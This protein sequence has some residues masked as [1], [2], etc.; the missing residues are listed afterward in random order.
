MIYVSEKHCVGVAD[1]MGIG[2]RRDGCIGLLVFIR[3]F[4]PLRIQILLSVHALRVKTVPTFRCSSE[5]YAPSH[6]YRIVAG[7]KP[8]E[9]TYLT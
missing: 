6:R 7:P 9:D 5:R 1:Q 8:T 4:L 2:I 3:F